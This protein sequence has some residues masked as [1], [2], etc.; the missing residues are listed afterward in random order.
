[1][2][3]VA[4]KTGHETPAEA[5]YRQLFAKRRKGESLVSAPTLSEIRVPLGR[6]TAFA[7]R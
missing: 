6:R 5:R 7:C 4:R 2:R 1:M 3:Q